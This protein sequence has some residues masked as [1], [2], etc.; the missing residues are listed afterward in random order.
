M[1]QILLPFGRG[2][3]ANLHCHSTDSDGAFTPV[4]LK[5]LYISQGYSVLA[6]TDHG[7]MKD[8]THLCDKNFVALSGYENHLE[9][10]WIRHAPRSNK[11]YHICFYAPRPDEVGMIGITDY[12]YEFCKSYNGDDRDPR[13]IKYGFF[14]G[15]NGGFGAENLNKL[16]KQAEKL[17]YLAVLNHPHWSHLSFEDLADIEGLFGIEIY[18]H[19]GFIYGDCESDA[20]YDMMLI[21]GRLPYCFAGDDNHNSKVADSFGGYNVLY[22][23]E[24]TYDGV[25]SC[26]RSGG[27]YAS[28]GAELNGL[29][30]DGNDVEVGTRDAKSVWIIT[31]RNAQ[32]VFANGKPLSHATFSVISDATYFRIVAENRDG[33]K[34]FSRAYKRGKNGRWI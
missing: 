10:P 6:Y 21:N 12:Y 29:T 19:N 5:E 16:L 23:E 33:K 34:A 1:K 27:F 26:L 7:C 25:F 24:L 2:Y 30:A 22:P 32:R 15:D 14:G 9:P 8:R 11:N 13:E 17:G 18:N 3:K 20:V 31:D 28:T 4:E